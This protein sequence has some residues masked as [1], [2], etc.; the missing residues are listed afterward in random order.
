M[1]EERFE[2]AAE[3]IGQIPGQAE[4]E[5]AF[6]DYFAETAE[7]LSVMAEEY[8]W[9]AGGG[10]QAASL[11]EL[12]RHNEI[13]FIDLLG[14]NYETSFANPAWARQRL[15]ETFGGLLSAVAA[16]LRSLPAFVYEQRLEEVTIRLELFLEIYCA[17]AES[18]QEEGSLPRESGIRDIFY[19]FASDYAEPMARNSAAETVDWTRD[20]AVRLIEESDLSDIRYLFYY[21]EYIADDQWKLAEYLNGLEQEKIQKIADAYTEGFRKG[22]EVAGKP[23]ERKKSVNIR[24]PLGFE[25]VVRA[26]IQNF[27]AMGLKPVI[28]RASSSFLQGRRGYKNGYFGAPVNLQFDYDH[29]NDKA[30]YLDKKYINRKLECCQ[31]AWEEYREQAALH[32]GPAVIEAFGEQPFEP[33]SKPERA[34]LS[35]EQQKLSVEYQSRHS[36]LVNRYINPEERS[37]TIIAFPLPQIGE[38]FPAIFEE[39]LKINTLD[40][41]TYETIQQRIIDALDQAAWVRVRG[42]GENRTDMKVMLHPLSDPEKETNFENCVADVNIPVGEVFTSPQLAGT[43]GTLHVTQVYLNGMKYTDLELA[44]EDGKI[45]SCSC[46]NFPDEAENRKLLQDNLLFHHDTLPIGEFA[47]GTNTTAYM[48]A[49]RFDINDKLPILIAEKTGPHFAVGD[50]C[51]SYEEDRMT[52]NPDGKAIIARD[53]EI[54]ALRHEDP[55]RAYFNCHTDITIPYDELGEVTA[56]TAD[57]REIGIIRDG[58]F[59]LDGTEELNVP[60]YGG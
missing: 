55:A 36:A 32:A 40:Y 59:V 27:R 43:N 49:K 35:A 9:I 7:Y 34:Q 44:F 17:F 21:G 54:S 52:Y 3:R 12:E 16:E 6:R 38:D 30:F 47:I 8:R 37:F 51:Y 41:K 13:C 48:A 56:V 5:G 24:Y 1:I 53:N 28:Y 25:R 2:L 50:T 45:A 58:F 57:G 14:R 39:I 10:L 31:S 33:V 18:W 15:G 23:L 11:Q 42:R 20:F 19:W 22:F 46:K 4:T 60:L 26:A 29:E